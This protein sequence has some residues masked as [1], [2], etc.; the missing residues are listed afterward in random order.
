MSKS[1]IKHS[2][3]VDLKEKEK[4]NS[5]YVKQILKHCK[6]TNNILQ[7]S[8]SLKPSKKCRNSISVTTDKQIIINKISNYK[9]LS[10][11]LHTISQTEPKYG[12]SSEINSEDRFDL[13]GKNKKKVKHSN[14]HSNLQSRQLTDRDLVM[15]EVVD[16][17]KLKKALSTCKKV[18]DTSK[19]KAKSFSGKNDD[20]N[21][22]CLC[23]VF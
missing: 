18:E 19:G 22:S 15:T 1:A 6:N 5:Q 10:N 4:P 23:I 16:V 8:V 21:C 14:A 11:I 3:S 9:E 2:A 13:F 17:T 7:R 12:G 20:Q